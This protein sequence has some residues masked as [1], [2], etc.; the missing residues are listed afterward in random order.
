VVR[1]SAASDVYKRQPPRSTIG[2]AAVLTAI[3][4]NE[5]RCGRRT[6]V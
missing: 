6:I 2:I 5:I 3:E 1:S 4:Y